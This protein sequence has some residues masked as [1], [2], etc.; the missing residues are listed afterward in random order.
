MTDP[1]G[2]SAATVGR[3]PLLLIDLET[4]ERVTGRTYLFAAAKTEW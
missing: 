4:E 3:A 2:T 1:L